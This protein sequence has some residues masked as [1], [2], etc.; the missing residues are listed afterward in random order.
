M[1]AVVDIGSNS[2]KY[3]LAQSER[4]ALVPIESGSWVTRLGKNLETNGGYLE[5]ESLDST[6]KALVEIA[7]RIRSSRK[8]EKLRVAAT[9]AARNAKNQDALARLVEKHLGADL[10]I[11]SG[12]DEALWSM[13]GALQAAE[14]HFPKDRFVFLDIGGASTE[15]GFIKPKF[16]AHS[17]DGGALR[18]HQGLGLDKI[19]VNDAAWNDARIEI[20]KYFPEESYKSILEDYDPKNHRAVAVGGTLLLATSYCSP[21]LTSPAGSLVTRSEL[22]E[23]ANKVRRKSMKDR[24]SMHGMDQERADILPAGILILTTCLAR[25]GQDEVFVTGWGLR[26]G[27]LAS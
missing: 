26:H 27:L 5:Q 16:L 22:E 3:L 11:L 20:N 25:L 24:L 7:A 8:L 18:C 1:R 19:P 15:I 17:F 6:E 2:I 23:L 21:V 4:G 12:Q 9:A 13:R 14:Q 10:E